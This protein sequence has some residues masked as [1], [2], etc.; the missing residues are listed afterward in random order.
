MVTQSDK[1]VH[2]S[3]HD[4][5]NK[6]IT[7]P[8]TVTEEKVTDCD[9]NTSNVPRNSINSRGLWDMD[10]GYMYNERMY[11]LTMLVLDH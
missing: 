4:K 1:S 10:N 8:I 2:H 6:L 11:I 9:R 7:M 5:Q 3:G